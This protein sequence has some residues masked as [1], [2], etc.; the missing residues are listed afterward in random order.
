[1]GYERVD[2]V[3]RSPHRECSG[4]KV[5]FNDVWCHDMMI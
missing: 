2:E 1:M 5:V 3:E 4:E